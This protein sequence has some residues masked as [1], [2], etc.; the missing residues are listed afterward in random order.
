MYFGKSTYLIAAV[1]L[2]AGCSQLS[3]SIPIHNG[4]YVPDVNL[5]GEE[6]NKYYNDVGLCQREIL[7]RYGPKSDSNN[8]ITDLRHCLINKGYVLL[9]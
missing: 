7:N 3:G 9:S 1:T 8:A 5:Q 4:N 6:L 2:L